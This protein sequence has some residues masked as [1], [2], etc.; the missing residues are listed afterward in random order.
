MTIR[1]PS[2]L[3]TAE[4]K[5]VP[6]VQPDTSAGAAIIQDRFRQRFETFAAIIESE[7]R[8]EFIGADDVNPE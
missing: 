4:G 6:T 8:T 7:S 2:P 5:E 1:T 3:L